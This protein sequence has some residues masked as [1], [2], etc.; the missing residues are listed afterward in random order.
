VLTVF[1]NLHYLKALSRMAIDA[2]VH[3]SASPEELIA[4]T[5]TLSRQA[6]G[7]NAVISMPRSMLER[8]GDEPV[9]GLSER[10]TEVLVLGTSRIS[11]SL[12]GLLACAHQGSGGAG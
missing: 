12:G 2:Y 3:K 5:N 6:R 8:L 9:G 11:A 1:D 4:T 7:Q 10:E